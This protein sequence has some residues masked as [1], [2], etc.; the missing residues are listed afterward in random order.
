MCRLETGAPGHQ[1]AGLTPGKKST[2]CLTHNPKP[3]CE[4]DD[5]GLLALQESVDFF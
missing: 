5:L 3:L 4:I 2:A 1:S